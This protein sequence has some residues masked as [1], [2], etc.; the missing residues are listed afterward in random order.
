MLVHDHGDAAAQV[1][2][3]VA[4]LLSVAHRGRQRH[5]PY[6]LGQVD[7]DL[8]PDRAAGAVS[9]VVHLV[10][11]HVAEA[12]EG[13]RPRV[14]HVPQHL[15]GHDHNGRFAVDAVVA[16]EQADG[17][18]V[19]PAH[20][21]GVLLVGQRLD[22]RGVE[23]LEAALQGQVDGELPDHGLAGAG[24]RGD[25]HAVALVQ[26]GAG[27]DLK[28]VELEVIQRAEAGELRM[29]LTVTE[30][31]VAL[32]GGP[33]VRFRGAIVSPVERRGHPPSLGVSSG[34]CGRGRSRCRSSPAATPRPCP[35][36]RPRHRPG[37]RTG[38]GC[39]RGAGRW[40]R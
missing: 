27:L 25:Q 6:R 2:Q 9:E 3:P 22:R 35:V 17:P 10:E 33:C 18:A 26:R 36:A 28:V 7:D 1:V 24:R 15:G 29:R 4:E 19:V 37:P 16:G 13:G 14:E 31:R 32:R 8:F 21:V 23:A 40:P 12:L 39:G 20:Q 34:C 38:P 11:D 5:H 30:L